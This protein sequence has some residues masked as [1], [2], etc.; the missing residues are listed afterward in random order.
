MRDLMKEIQMGVEEGDAEAVKRVTEF[1]LHEGIGAK[2]II[3]E[4]LLPIMERIGKAFRSG[5]IYIPDVLMSSRA[6][7]ASLYVLK[8][9][10]S[11]YDI[12]FYKRTIVIGTVAGDLHDIGKNMIAMVLKGDGYRV[13]DL[14]IDV[15]AESFV[16]AVKH[17]Q[18][19]L[20]AISALLTT[21][22]GEL[23]NVIEAIEDAGIRQS[24][25]IAFG[26]G[27][28]TQEY[29]EN[30]GADGYGAEAFD[31]VAMVSN[32]LKK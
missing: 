5:E 22:M 26:G 10:M 23:K 8:P 27:P 2:R 25:K 29:A 17:Y 28:V 14:G 21:T 4:G 24:I 31:A 9:L 32:L 18:P 15:P 20:L 13:I 19:D 30:I 3:E 1:S 11:H 12:G 16:T 7:H 6:V